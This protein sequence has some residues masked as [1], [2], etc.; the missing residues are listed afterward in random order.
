M[1]TQ[2]KICVVLLGLLAGAGALMGEVYRVAMPSAG[3]D[4][5]NSGLDWTLPKASISNALAQGDVTEV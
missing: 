4:D 1:N 3:G 2:A 5:G